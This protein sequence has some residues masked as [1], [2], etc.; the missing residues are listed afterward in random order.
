MIQS[1]SEGFPQEVVLGFTCRSELVQDHLIAIEVRYNRLKSLREWHYREFT[2]KFLNTT[3]PG[4]HKVKTSTKIKEIYM[5]R[6]LKCMPIAK[7]WE[8][9]GKV[10]SNMPRNVKSYT[11][12]AFTAVAAKRQEGELNVQLFVSWWNRVPVRLHSSE[13]Q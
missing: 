11:Q 3:R 9:A 8:D 12:S 1:I 10:R 2:C 4:I 6:R 13:E 5:P 7:R